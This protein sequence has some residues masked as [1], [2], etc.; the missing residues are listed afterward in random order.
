MG[1]HPAALGIAPG[2]IGERLLDCFLFLPRRRRFRQIDDRSFRVRWMLVPDRGQ[3]L[4]QAVLD[5]LHCVAPLGAEDVGVI[6]VVEQ[7]I[8]GGF[9]KPATLIGDA[10]DRNVEIVFNHW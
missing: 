3:L 1:Q 9:Y 10:S 8:A 6:G 2:P 4:V 5:Q 7:R